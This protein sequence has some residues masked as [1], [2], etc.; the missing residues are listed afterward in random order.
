MTLKLVN[1]KVN[2][3]KIFWMSY[4][5]ILIENFKKESKRLIKKFPSL[6]QELKALNDNP[7]IGTPLAKSVIKYGWQ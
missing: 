6:K 1:G 3:L 2:P 4:S 5:V 7:A